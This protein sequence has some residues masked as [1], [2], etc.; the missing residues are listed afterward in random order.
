MASLDTCVLASRSKPS[1][2]L[3]DQRAQLVI[4]DFGLSKMEGRSTIGATSTLRREG[5]GTS[6]YMAPESWSEEDFGKVSFKSDMWSLGCIM[7]EM[8]S[9]TTPWTKDDGT[10]LREQQIMTS[11]IVKRRAPKVPDGLL[12]ELASLLRNCFEFEQAKRPTAAA[13]RTALI[14]HVAAQ[15]AQ[16][17]E[18]AVDI[19]DPSVLMRKVMTLEKRLSLSGLPI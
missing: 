13:F 5:V 18:Q 7:V 16:R 19:A 2:V 15:R 6:F 11:I 3:M 1:N 8:L 10:V 17:T 4:C 14:E 9:G 12:P